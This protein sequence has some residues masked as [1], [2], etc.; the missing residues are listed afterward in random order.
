MDAT[1]S[2]ERGRKCL[3]VDKNSIKFSISIHFDALDRLEYF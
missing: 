2:T 1:G 3:N